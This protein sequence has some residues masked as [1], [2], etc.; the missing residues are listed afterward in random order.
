[1]P[2]YEYECSDCG[3]RFEEFQSIAAKPIEVC[4]KC[5][6]KHVR[7]IIFGGVGLIFKGSGF[8]IT[9]YARKNSSNNGSSGKNGSVKCK[10]EKAKTTA[11]KEK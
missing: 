1:M 3:Y 6:G 7:R 10:K 9:D 11:S 5:H 8:Y 4:P 2:T